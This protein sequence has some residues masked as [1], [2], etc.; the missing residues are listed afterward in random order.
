MLLCSFL[1]PIYPTLSQAWITLVVLLNDIKFEKTVFLK[2]FSRTTEY[3]KN[4]LKKYIAFEIKLKKL[5]DYTCTNT[6]IIWEKRKQLFSKI[7]EGFTR[8][9]K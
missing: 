9:F 8:I 1:Y 3:E 5:Q 2:P 6:A 7:I 4:S